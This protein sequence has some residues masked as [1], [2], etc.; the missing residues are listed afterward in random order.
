MVGSKSTDGKPTP[1]YTG[2]WRIQLRLI[3]RLIEKY[4]PVKFGQYYSLYPIRFSQFWIW[5]TESLISL[6]PSPWKRQTDQ[7]TH[8]AL[9]KLCLAKFFPDRFSHEIP[10]L[11]VRLLSSVQRYS[12]VHLATTLF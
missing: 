1:Y 3:S 11:N 7:E 4:Y 12:T 5:M 2:G 10:G 9:G 8:V 6:S